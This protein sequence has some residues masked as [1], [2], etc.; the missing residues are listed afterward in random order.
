MTERQRQERQAFA[1]AAEIVCRWHYL[2][3][4]NRT[5]SAVALTEAGAFRVL[6]A[7]HPGVLPTKYLGKTPTYG[8]RAQQRKAYVEVA[9]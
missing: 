9:S 4:G 3:N 7:E 2:I 1:S 8:N 6:N 5:F